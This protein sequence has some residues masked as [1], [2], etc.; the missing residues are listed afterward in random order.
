M[1]SFW[2][3]LNPYHVSRWQ[4]ITC[5]ALHPG[6]IHTGL[7]REDNPARGLPYLSPSPPPMAQGGGG[8]LAEGHLSASPLLVGGGPVRYPLA[9]AGPPPLLTTHPYTHTHIPAPPHDVGPSAEPFPCPLF[10]LI[11]TPSL[12]RGC[13]SACVPCCVP[14]FDRKYTSGVVAS[15]PWLF[16]PTCPPTL[17]WLFGWLTELGPRAKDIGVIVEETPPWR[18]LSL[19]AFNGWPSY[20]G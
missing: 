5:C 3:L 20:I 16:D 1:D 12:G 11:C 15:S 4:G 19:I 14:F 13:F 6:V 9:P 7:L 18:G 17:K 10:A 2:F 8:W